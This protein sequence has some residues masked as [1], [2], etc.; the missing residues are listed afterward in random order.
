MVVV[1]APVADWSAVGFGAPK[2]DGRLVVSTVA[3]ARAPVAA[4]SIPL[5]MPK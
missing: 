5:E 2:A 1:Q 3:S 4:A